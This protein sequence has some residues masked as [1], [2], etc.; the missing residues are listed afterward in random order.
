MTLVSY[1][2]IHVCAT[3]GYSMYI[4]IYIYVYISKFMLLKFNVTLTSS[5]MCG[6]YEHM[7]QIKQ[8]LVECINCIKIYLGCILV[9]VIYP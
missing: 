3:D 9:R 5:Y 8:M 4:Y 6:T 1:L 2:A 7:N